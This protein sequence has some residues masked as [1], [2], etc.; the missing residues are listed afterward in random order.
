LQPGL[1]TIDW[2]GGRGQVT[3]ANAFETEI[4]FLLQHFNQLKQESRKR[5]AIA[6][7]FGLA[8]DLAYSSVTLNDEDQRV[9]GGVFRAVLRKVGPPT[10]IVRLRCSASVEQRRIRARG[11]A[12]ERGIEL[13]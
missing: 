2:Y 11:R 10:L 8:L 7:D 1:L 13:R 5:S 4:T 6:F 12:A 9:F 3:A